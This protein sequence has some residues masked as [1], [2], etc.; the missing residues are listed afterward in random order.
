MVPVQTLYSSELL[1]PKANRPWWADGRVWKEIFKP[2]FWKGGKAGLLDCPQP[3]LGLASSKG[4][5]PLS[6]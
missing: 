3:F 2:P 1:L 5:G 4:A 6:F